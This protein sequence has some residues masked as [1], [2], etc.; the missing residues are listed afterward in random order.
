MKWGA[1]ELVFFSIVVYGLATSI[2][3]LHAGKVLVRD[4][5]NW[6]AARIWIL[7]P[8][9]AV[10]CCPACLAFWIGLC[11]SAADISPIHGLFGSR[12]ADVLS[13]SCDGFFALGSTW[14]LHV[15]AEKL[16]HGLEL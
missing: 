3:V 8:L 13:L 6:I 10:V 15:T 14:L 11:L 16:G 9:A 12:Y 7:K 2:A 4:P 1:T 5:L